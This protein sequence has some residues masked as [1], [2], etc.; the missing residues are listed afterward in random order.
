MTTYV[1][2]YM[3]IITDIPLVSAHG[4][5]FPLTGTLRSV[6]C[7]FSFTASWLTPYLYCVIHS[8]IYFVETW[9]VSSKKTNLLEKCQVFVAAED[10]ES[11]SGKKFEIWKSLTFTSKIPAIEQVAYRRGIRI[12]KYSRQNKIATPV[13]G[14]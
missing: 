14:S 5:G 2:S 12:K 11:G 4:N 9:D 7:I 3:T 8:E 10:G 1:T 13:D 6:S